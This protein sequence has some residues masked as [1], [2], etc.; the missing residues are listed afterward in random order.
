MSCSSYS[1]CRIIKFYNYVQNKNV[2]VAPTWDPMELYN[3]ARPN[4]YYEYKEWKKRDREERSLRLAIE[5]QEKDKK[6]FRSKSYSDSEYSYSDDDDRP[7]KNGTSTLT[8]RF[9]VLNSSTEARWGD[10]N[11]QVHDFPPAVVDIAMSGEEVYA[12]RLAL[13]QSIVAPRASSPDPLPI[14]ETG[15]EAYQRRLAMSQVRGIPVPVHERAPAPVR[16]PSPA[17]E[18]EPP[19]SFNPFAPPSVPP[20][21]PVPMQPSSGTGVQE[22][23]F[24]AR[25]KHSREAAAAVAARLAKLAA[26]APT[27]NT[28]D[29]STKEKTEER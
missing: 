21:P 15:E 9:L 17:Q 12:R 28:E 1:S 13:S 19:L 11:T 25:L 2:P 5:R 20:P 22:P 29:T 18:T 26:S 6:R 23:D 24:E 7:R 4:D 27:E 14:A 8:P 3:P 10:D 16:E